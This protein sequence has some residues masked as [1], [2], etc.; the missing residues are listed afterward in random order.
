MHRGR[1]SHLYLI[2]FFTG[3]ADRHWTLKPLNTNR[4]KEVFNKNRNELNFEILNTFY[5]TMIK[6]SI[7][8]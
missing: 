1:V 7:V 5:C 6:S 2:A 4:R 3:R 8:L